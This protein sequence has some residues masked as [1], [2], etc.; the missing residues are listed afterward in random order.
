[1]WG[2]VDGEEE[3]EDEKSSRDG[4]L[5]T[6]FFTVGV[7]KIQVFFVLFVS[8]LVC[9]SEKSGTKNPD[10]LNVIFL[11]VFLCSLSLFPL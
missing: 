1:V 9:F 6:Y 3:E 11:V 8:L 7:S 5:S 10:W 2:D 4:G